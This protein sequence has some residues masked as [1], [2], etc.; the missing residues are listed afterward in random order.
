MAYW[1]KVPMISI[2]KRQVL[3]ANILNPPADIANITQALLDDGHHPDDLLPIVDKRWG[4]RI[5]NLYQNK[6]WVSLLF[7]LLE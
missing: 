3:Q 5:K 2:F 6:I 4:M 7:C 1:V